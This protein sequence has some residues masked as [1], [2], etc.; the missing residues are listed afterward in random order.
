MQKI[1]NVKNVKKI[2][3]KPEK[4]KEDKIKEKKRNIKK[5]KE[6]V[7]KAKIKKTTRKV[8]P[9]KKKKTLKKKTTKQKRAKRI[10]T[11]VF[12]VGSYVRKKT[13][14][15]VSPGFVE[16]EISR[17]KDQLDIDVSEAE[18]IATSM[19]MK[20]LMEV[21]AIRIYDFKMP[22]RNTIISCDHCGRSFLVHVEDDKRKMICP[23]CGQKRHLKFQ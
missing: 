7:N 3:L 1:K 11:N 8:K 18:Q 19:G 4:K 6:K 22:D 17:I 14:L 16:E 21:H 15:N 12:N 9:E 10:N 5:K 23:F 2:K 13:K 20:T